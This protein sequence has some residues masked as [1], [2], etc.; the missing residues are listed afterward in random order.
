MHF[1]F[2]YILCI[3]CFL[4]FICRIVFDDSIRNRVDEP[5][6]EFHMV[7]P[8]YSVYKDLN[9]DRTLPPVTQA[10]FDDFLAASDMKFGRND[11]HSGIYTILFTLYRKKKIIYITF[12]QYSLLFCLCAIHFFQFRQLQLLLFF[13]FFLTKISKINLCAFIYILFHDFSSVI[14]LGEIFM[15]QSKKMHIK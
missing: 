2:N 3:F 12:M 4:F 13:C 1:I 6:V 5:A 8:E 14:D 11:L 15:K 10:R 9:A 7:L